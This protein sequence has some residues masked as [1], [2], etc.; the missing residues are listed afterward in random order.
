M[1]PHEAAIL[2]NVIG[3]RRVLDT[4]LTIIETNL[5]MSL[6]FPVFFSRVSR[7]FDFFVRL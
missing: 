2:E 4:V 5:P 1:Y 6:S 7:C 3:F